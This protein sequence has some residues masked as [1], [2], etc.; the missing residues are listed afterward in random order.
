MNGSVQELLRSFGQGS[1]LIIRVA[2]LIGN[3]NWQSAWLKLL[4]ERNSWYT[5]P[6]TYW[7]K[8]LERSKESPV[9][10]NLNAVSNQHNGFRLKKSTFV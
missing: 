2:K 9:N 1:G 8:A 4:P 3:K 5:I 7:Q 10:N 6:R